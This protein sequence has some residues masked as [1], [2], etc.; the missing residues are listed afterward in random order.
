MSL[1]TRIPSWL[2][3]EAYAERLFRKGDLGV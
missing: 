1:W 3:I 2:D